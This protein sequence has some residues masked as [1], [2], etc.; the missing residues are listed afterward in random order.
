MTTVY[1]PRA[2]LSPQVNPGDAPYFEAAA[3]NKLLIKQCGDCGEYHFYPRALC[4]FCFSDRTEWVEASG[5]G[6]IYTYSVTRRAGPVAYAIAFVTLD[7]GVVMMTNI[8]DCDLDA[9]L[10][11]QRVKAVFKPTENGQAVPCFTSE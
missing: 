11:G 2:M 7:E 5:Q 8:V 3:E 6:T 1:E 4:P 9:V 10:I